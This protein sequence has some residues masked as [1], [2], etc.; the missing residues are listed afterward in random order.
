MSIFNYT[1]AIS[2]QSSW[3]DKVY[4]NANSGEM[5]IVVGNDVY[6]Y[7]DVSVEDWDA[8]INSSSWGSFYQRNKYDWTR[9]G[10]ESHDD[11][12]FQVEFE[13]QEGNEQA[14]EPTVEIDFDQLVDDLEDIVVT[15]VTSIASVLRDFAAKNLK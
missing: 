12:E 10:Y 9:L 4:Y 13:D 15:A 8:M 7:G 6:L 14:T 2:G 3:I 1:S 5:A 11:L